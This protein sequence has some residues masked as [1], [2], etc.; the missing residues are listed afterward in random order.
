M[1][2]IYYLQKQNSTVISSSR[3][4]LS[5][6]SL[7]D[8]SFLI[9]SFFLRQRFEGNV[10]SWF[11]FCHPYTIFGFQLYILIGS[12]SPHSQVGIQIYLSGLLDEGCILD[13]I[14]LLI[15]INYSILIMCVGVLFVYEK[16]K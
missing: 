5:P 4:V 2:P 6:G 13:F 12:I 3:D 15:N 16:E 14:L 9:A 7:L 11:L 10:D 8:K 1:V